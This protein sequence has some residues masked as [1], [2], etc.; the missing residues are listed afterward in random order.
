MKKILYCGWV[1][2]GNL[3]DDYMW[4]IFRGLCDKYLLDQVKIT[5]TRPGLRINEVKHYDLVVMG[6]GSLIS[7]YYINIIYRARKFNIPVIVWGSGID[8]VG[9]GKLDS[10][11]NQKKKQYTH[12]LSLD[13]EGKLKKLIPEIR[14][15]S[16]R[17]PL[18][19]SIIE[20]IY[21]KT[22]N[23]HVSGDPGVLINEQ[24]L[25]RKLDSKQTEVP[26]DLKTPCIA[27]N[28]GTVY[29]E[30]YGGNEVKLRKELARA[31][32]ELCN[33]GYHLLLYSVWPEDIPSLKRLRDEISC[34]NNVKIWLKPNEQQ[35]L[36][37]L[38]QCEY[39]INF[40]LHANIL[41][42]AAGT[43][44]IALGYRFKVYDFFH[45]VNLQ[46]LVLPADSVHFK[47][48]VLERHKYVIENR[49]TLKSVYE[50]HE[51]EY[52]QRIIDSF[53]TIKNVLS[54]SEI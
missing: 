32:K 18:T 20:K 33:E 49:S 13:V 42:L 29:N 10:L 21:G 1:G 17:G 34:N 5:Y 7:S 8:R 3:G 40:K 9:K 54:L 51:K 12:Y 39:S 53:L 2:R 23:T 28:W 15:F 19:Y 26:F 46:Q 14:S 37:A 31:L 22:S 47:E 27:V 52:K 41:S 25:L 4:Y 6:G 48:E 16:V 38:S 45:S 24:D 36:I 43:P 44:A 11:L 30:L 35:L 50:S